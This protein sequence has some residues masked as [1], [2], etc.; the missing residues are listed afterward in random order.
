M[1]ATTPKDWTLD[2]LDED[3]LAR[4]NLQRIPET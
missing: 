3:Q 2:M 4:M 1:M